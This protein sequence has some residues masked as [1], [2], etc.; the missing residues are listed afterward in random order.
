MR[1]P[2]SG[3]IV[4]RVGAVTDG[5]RSVT[6]IGDASRVCDQYVNVSGGRMK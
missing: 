4:T 6:R 3:Y 5:T 1:F 2:L